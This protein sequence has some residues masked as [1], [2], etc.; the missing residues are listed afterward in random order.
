M[1]MWAISV[2]VARGINLPLPLLVTPMPGEDGAVALFLAEAELKRGATNAE[3][4]NPNPAIPNP[5]VMPM[6]GEAGLLARLLRGQARKPAIISAG[7]VKRKAVVPIQ[8]LWHPL[9][10]RLVTRQFWAVPRLI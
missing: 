2:M 5:V 1:E 6:P 3:E 10:L 4:P 8:L 7:A 9:F